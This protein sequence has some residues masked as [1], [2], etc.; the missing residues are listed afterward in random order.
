[1]SLRPAIVLL[2]LALAAGCTDERAPTAAPLAPTPRLLRWAGNRAPQ[3]VAPQ[4]GNDGLQV[5]L[6]DGLSLDHNSVTFWA[7]RGEQRSVQVN[8]LSSTGNTSSP[9]LNLSITDPVFVPGRGELAVG[10]S[11][12]VTVNIDP[13]AIKVSLEP[14]GTQFGE[15]A[16]LKI[17][18]GGADGDMNGDGV[19]NAADAQIETQLLGLWY[20]EG[21]DSAWTQIPA[22]QSLGD[23]SFSGALHHFSEYAVSFLDYAVSW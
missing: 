13:S 5:S 9:F 4:T 3:F 2:A 22:S 10:D 23:N 21:E 6:V 7:V 17:S 1:M 20:R 15:P 12:L 11:V 19:V 8:Y 18:Y 16:Q 14:T